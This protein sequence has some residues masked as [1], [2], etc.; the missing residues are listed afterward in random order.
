MCLK[1][2]QV[3]GRSMA[4]LLLAAFC[5]ACGESRPLD[6]TS[7]QSVPG[8]YLPDYAFNAEA[9][10][11]SDPAI[12]PIRAEAAASTAIRLCLFL[13]VDGTYRGFV[14]HPFVDG[15]DEAERGTWAVQGSEVVLERRTPDGAIATRR[16]RVAGPHLYTNH[17]ESRA[18]VRLMRVQED[19]WRAAMELEGWDPGVTVCPG[20]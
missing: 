10:R 6:S 15:R 13:Q 19:R 3:S 20:G 11:R 2:C 18:E 16:F 8:F 14:P 4:L 1:N 17:A 7:E 9:L 12:A 5:M